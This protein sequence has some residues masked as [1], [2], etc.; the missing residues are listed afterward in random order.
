MQL[1]DSHHE[2]EVVVKQQST[3]HIQGMHT[4][5]FVLNSQFLKLESM[6]ESRLKDTEEC[7]RKKESELKDL[8]NFLH[9]SLLSSPGII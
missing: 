9:S 8:E 3:P 5:H 2:V 4:N 1:E 6:L 7:L